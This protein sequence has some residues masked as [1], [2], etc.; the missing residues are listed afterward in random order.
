MARWLL[1]FTP[2]VICVLVDIVRLDITGVF[3][4]GVILL[5]LWLRSIDAFTRSFWI[6]DDPDQD[7]LGSL[8]ELQR[9]GARRPH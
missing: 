6:A 3:L 8:D 7:A 5:G 9:Y 2:G 1:L 4:V